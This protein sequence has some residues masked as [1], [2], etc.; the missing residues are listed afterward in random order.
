MV[1]LI[2]RQLD[3]FIDAI[4]NPHRIR[5]QKNTIMADRIPNHIFNFPE[6]YG[7][8]ESGKKTYSSIFVTKFHF[9]MC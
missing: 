7:M 8:K 4:W 6:K 1:P 9:E 2:Q 3:E 5:H